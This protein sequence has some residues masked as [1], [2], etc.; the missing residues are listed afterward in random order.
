MQTIFNFNA[1]HFITLNK[2]PIKSFYRIGKILGAGSFSQVRL[3]V[4]RESGTQRAVKVIYKE[5]LD[6]EEM[7]M[8]RNE[9]EILKQTDHPSIIR[10]YEW[11]EDDRRIYLILEICKGGELLTEITNKKMFTEQQTAII[12]K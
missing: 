5:N 2:G 7:G 10:L 9:I 12:M 11:F 4:N 8:V 6:G 3:C 1:S